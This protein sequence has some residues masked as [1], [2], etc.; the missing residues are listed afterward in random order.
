M[1]ILLDT[2]IFIP[3]EDSSKVLDDSLCDLV[4]LAN[5]HG[6]HLLVHPASKEDIARD[7]DGQR[8]AISLSRINKY[9]LLESPPDLSSEKL[10]VL[11]LSQSKDNDR[12]D[13]LIL[14]ALLRDAVDLLVTEDRGM[15]KKSIQLG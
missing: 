11:G 9:P 1:R 4:K 10:L 13:N 6:H 8:R 14:Y 15:H 7:S 12:V 5:Q 2:N 3:L